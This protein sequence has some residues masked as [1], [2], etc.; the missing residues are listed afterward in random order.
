MSSTDGKDEHLFVNLSEFENVGIPRQ[1]ARG[2]VIKGEAIRLHGRRQIRV[3]EN[4]P[5]APKI[6]VHKEGDRVESVEFV[7]PCGKNTSLRFDY[8]QETPPTA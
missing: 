5:G 4:G 2:N 8:D 3:E 1:P 6:V 7:C